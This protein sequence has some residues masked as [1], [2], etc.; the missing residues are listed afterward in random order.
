MK[1]CAVF[2]DDGQIYNAIIRTIDSVAQTCVVYYM[3][4]GNEEEHLLTDLLPPNTP[5]C[6]PPSKTPSQISDAGSEKDVRIIAVTGNQIIN[7]H[8]S[9]ICWK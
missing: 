7:G 5:A 9:N 1:C 4:Y 8:H 3:G 6:K 2:T